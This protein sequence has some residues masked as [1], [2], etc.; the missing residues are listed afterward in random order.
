[1]LL[2]DTLTRKQASG[3]EESMKFKKLTNAQRSGLN[4]IPNRY[5]IRT[6]LEVTLLL[7]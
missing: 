4:Q 1:M 7:T 3:F 5:A 6:P 2:S